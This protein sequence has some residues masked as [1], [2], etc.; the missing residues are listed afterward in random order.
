MRPARAARPRSRL[1][2][3]GLTLVEVALLVCVIGVLLAV[4]VPTFIS[5]LRTSK[6]S[7]AATQLQALHEAAAAYFAAGHEGEDGRTRRQCL[8]PAAGPAPAEPSA[9]PVDFDFDGEDAPG[10]ETW[11]ALGFDVDRPIRYR[12]SFVPAESGCGLEGGEGPLLTLRAEGDLDD[13]GKRS[14]FEREADVNDEGELV[15]VGILYMLDRTE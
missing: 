6:V 1:R 12:Y 9:D 7:E 2:R 10:H 11:Q 3:T 15:P 13:D 5:H 4:F 8:P 14:L